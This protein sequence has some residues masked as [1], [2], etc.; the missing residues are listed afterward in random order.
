MCVA[1]NI[2]DSL[3]EEGDDVLDFGLY[4]DDDIIPEIRNARRVNPD[5]VAGRLDKIE[6]LETILLELQY[7][8]YGFS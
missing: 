8:L 2:P 3:P 1:H 4:D 6:Q 7:I 5:L